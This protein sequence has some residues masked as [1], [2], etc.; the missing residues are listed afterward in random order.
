[1]KMRGLFIFPCW[2]LLTFFSL[3][4]ADV[5][6]HKNPKQ[7][8]QHL[9]R[10]IV[11]VKAALAQI[12]RNMAQENKSFLA[13]EKKMVEL[14]QR[15]KSMEIDAQQKESEIQNRLKEMRKK[16]LGLHLVIEGQRSGATMAELAG[17]KLIVKKLQQELIQMNLKKDQWGRLTSDLKLL[18]SDYEESRKA[19]NQIFA[20]LSE[21]QMKRQGLEKIYIK[22]QKYQGDLQI[23]ITNQTMLKATQ[24]R[25]EIENIS[26]TFGIPVQQFKELKVENS[27]VSFFID[28]DVPVLAPGKG[29]V[30]YIGGLASYGQV[31]MIDHGNDLRT[32]ILGEL[33]VN[34]E[35]NLQVNEGDVLGYAQKRKGQ[36]NKVY[37]EVR[38]RETPQAAMK[39][40]K[41]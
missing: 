28:Q 41:I 1:M 3:A 4:W 12:D 36:E 32:L 40:L 35:R 21:L 20:A 27:G 38:K 29:K 16:F 22:T 7:D 37:F 39:Y 23:K 30:V 2:A 18:R 10:D 15:I 17:Q 5:T 11:K 24:A 34:V 8:L 26:G 6:S 25:S 19:Q 9:D 31:I 33:K 13:Q 14:E